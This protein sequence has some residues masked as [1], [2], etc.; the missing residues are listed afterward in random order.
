MNDA[1]SLPLSPSTSASVFS[2]PE[3]SELRPTRKRSFP[4]D[5]DSEDGDLDKDLVKAFRCRGHV[6][7]RARGLA[8]RIDDDVHKSYS[9]R[10]AAR[11]PWQDKAWKSELSLLG[12]SSP[13]PLSSLL[14]ERH[15]DHLQKAFFQKLNT[16][17]ILSESSGMGR[18][19]S[20][21]DASEM[22]EQSRTFLAYVRDVADRLADEGGG[23][24]DRSRMLAFL[25]NMQRQ[26]ARVADYP[27]AV[28]KP[29]A[30][31]AETL[32]PASLLFHLLLD[33]RWTVLSAVKSLGQA[34]ESMDLVGDA[35]V[36][37]T[38]R[39]VLPPSSL[40]SSGGVL[41]E[42][43]HELWV[44]LVAELVHLAMARLRQQ[45]G[46]L[47]SENGLTR[48]FAT[49]SPFG[50][51]CVEELWHLAISHMG[52]EQF[53][54]VFQLATKTKWS[55]EEKAAVE[56]DV[57]VAPKY[58]L[59][60]LNEEPSMATAK[61]WLLHNL[62][63]LL[64]RHAESQAT[65]LKILDGLLK[66]S[67][68][69]MD[70]TRFD[71]STVKCILQVVGRAALI[72]GLSIQTMQQLW[73][74]FLKRIHLPFRSSQTISLDGVASMPTSVEIWSKMLRLA[75]YAEESAQD[76]AAD[77]LRK[78]TRNAFML[79]LTVIEIQFRE[80][81]NGGAVQRK[82]SFEKFLGRM[83]SQITPKKLRELTDVGWFH[84]LSV[85]L[86][87]LKVSPNPG[88]TSNKMRSILDGVK[89]AEDIKSSASLTHL[90]GQAVM[91][92]ELF[93][94]GCD[95]AKNIGQF[96]DCLKHL[97]SGGG[98]PLQATAGFEVYSELLRES[99]CHA[100]SV[101]SVL[102]QPKLLSPCVAAYITQGGGADRLRSVLSALATFITRLRKFCRSATYEELGRP[103]ATVE[104][105]ALLEGI[106]ATRDALWTNVF[107]PCFKSRLFSTVAA[108]EN[109]PVLTEISEYATQMVM[110][111]MDKPHSP[112][113][114]FDSLFP[115]FAPSK[116][117]V[118]PAPLSCHFMLNFL[119]GSQ[120]RVRSALKGTLCMLVKG[121]IRCSV[122]LG[123]KGSSIRQL[124]WEVFKLSEMREIR[125]ESMSRSKSDLNEDSFNGLDEFLRS[126]DTL[127]ATKSLSYLRDT[128]GDYLRTAVEVVRNAKV[129]EMNTEE[130]IHLYGVIGRLF[131]HG[132]LMLY[133]RTASGATT[134]HL[135]A[136]V[137]N[138]LTSPKMKQDGY[139]FSQ[140]V[141]NA[142]RPM[143]ASLVR[144]IAR[145][146]DFDT[147]SFLKRVLNDVILI[148]LPAFVSK[149]P[150]LIHPLSKAL[151]PNFLDGAQ[152][153]RLQSLFVNAIKSHFL[154]AEA[155]QKRRAMMQ[156]AVTF[157]Q[158]HL[159]LVTNG[160]DK[161]FLLRLATD[162]V[163][164]L[165]EA[166]I[167]HKDPVAGSVV[168]DVLRTMIKECR[169]VQEDD[170]DGKI[171]AALKSSLAR[172]VEQKMSWSWNDV[173]AILF[174]IAG[175]YPDL[176][177]SIMAGIEKA[178]QELMVKRN[179]ADNS[180][181][182]KKLIELK[183]LVG[184]N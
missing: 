25:C 102:S 117:G 181:V 3:T 179:Y 139:V 70:Q 100:P 31:R 136:L 60:S 113:T 101:E 128:Y 91:I 68:E 112:G 143:L 1:W 118:I 38:F 150:S 21:A 42:M 177:K 62:F 92:V 120:E 11:T 137:Q 135:N 71:E 53:A 124:S 167:M 94:R 77:D 14:D 34:G 75:N 123:G 12:L 9:D 28:A 130:T 166:A 155:M 114:S 180:P 154:T 148:Y 93:R 49:L 142:V 16:L 126:L 125:E 46:S 153:F 51:L 121:W 98:T 175:W 76:E 37:C 79:Y 86:V 157:L 7:V 174:K 10:N 134:N 146:P 82:K 40:S 78:G 17:E 156:S 182:Q 99:L 133:Y 44:Q 119:L 105:R 6:S 141:K 115:Y 61:W 63:P 54:A 20:A 151:L 30:S 171:F 80:G 39:P 52:V 15:S 19:E 95:P 64:A 144:G 90:R 106:D 66:D 89:G 74:F 163:E 58:D 140:M 26:L 85:F 24:E 165:C 176:I 35:A 23:A 8:G 81:D 162:V 45:Q 96:A 149:D 47:N 183:R 83:R 41:S 152:R 107:L 72:F 87:A 84:L 170:D 55:D 5:D 33:S 108:N 161:H 160:L 111:A 145:L 132:S 67:L 168:R 56:D 36:A 116:P 73:E 159:E 88:D 2:S 172:H 103:A 57:A 164:A 59:V 50:C 169:S 158:T 138:L 173:F 104:Q 110:L 18:S 65:A 69:E 147:D 97:S 129:Q 13:L 184:S 178:V 131:E 4:F 43:Q 32:C 48:F 122:L 27:A 29:S 127:S 109:R 22:A